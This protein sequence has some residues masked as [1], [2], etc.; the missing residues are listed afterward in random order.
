[1]KNLTLIPAILLSVISVNALADNEHQTSVKYNCKTITGTI[2][3][4]LPDPACNIK[5]E[6]L[7]H[8]PDVNFLGFPGTCFKSTLT[9][10]LGNIQ[11]TGTSYSGLTANAINDPA[12]LTAASVIRLNAGSDELGRVFTTDMT[13]LANSKE[14]LTMVDGSKIYNGGKGHLEITG[15]ALY[16]QTTFA[17]TLCSQN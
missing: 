7:G 17:G 12:I 4:L 6:Q 13:L 10:R 5:Q 1:M 3:P 14:N 16:E 15:N 9:A 2:A 11:V 8:F